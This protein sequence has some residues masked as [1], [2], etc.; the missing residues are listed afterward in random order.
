MWAYSTYCTTLCFQYSSLLSAALIHRWTRWGRH[1][2]SA[3]CEDGGGQSP[4]SWG[5]KKLLV[6]A[7]NLSGPARLPEGSA[8]K[9]RRR[10]WEGWQGLKSI[11]FAGSRLCKYVKIEVE[12]EVELLIFSWIQTEAF[13]LLMVMAWP[14][15]TVY[16]FSSINATYIIL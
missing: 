14:W 6:K 16:C 15:L 11:V 7:F 5:G 9:R 8:W 1:G 3:S 4:H 12:V 13:S 10:G 2:M